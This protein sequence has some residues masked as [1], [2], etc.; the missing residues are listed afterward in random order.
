MERNGSLRELEARREG[1]ALLDR[2]Q[3][4]HGLHGRPHPRNRVADAVA[5]RGLRDREVGLLLAG[6]PRRRN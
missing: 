3:L 4:A 6:R 1:R 2:R 5:R